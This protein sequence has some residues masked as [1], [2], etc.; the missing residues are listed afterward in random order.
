MRAAR[1]KTILVSRTKLITFIGDG[2]RSP[3]L[4]R[5]GLIEENLY[6][7]HLRSEAANKVLSCTSNFVEL[8]E[9]VNTFNTVACFT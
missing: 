5:R 9:K 4:G 7:I 3:F 1:S 2:W 6:K 8:L